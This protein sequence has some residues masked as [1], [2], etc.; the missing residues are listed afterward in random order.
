MLLAA[1]IVGSIPSLYPWG[2]AA[3]RFGERV[4]VT[5]GLGAAAI[6][7]AGAAFVS[8]FAGLVV[9]LFLAGAFGAAVNSST[10][11]AVM[12]WFG[13]SERGLALGVRQTSVPIAGFWVALTLPALVSGNDPRDAL[14]AVAAVCLAGA[15]GGLLVLRGGDRRSRRGRAAGSDARPRHLG[16]LRRQ[17]ADPRAAGVP[18]RLPG[19]VPARRA[20]PLHG[21]GRSRSRGCQR[22]RDRDPD[23]RRPLVGRRRQPAR[24]APADRARTDGARRRH[25]RRAR[26]A[27]LAPAPAPRRDRLC[28]DQLERPRVHCGGRGGRAWRGAARRSGCSRRCSPSAAGSCRSSSAR[29]WR[30]HRGGWASHSPL[31]LPLAGWATL[32]GLSG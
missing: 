32:R 3:D 2:M 5:T 26:R 29:W 8:S 31:L 21:G 14:L 28:R 13:A 17:R 11:R 18:R 10:G 9:L 7:L 16:A 12:H 20:R 6:C 24:A 25:G 19:R 23:R 22:A 1:P 4:A 15:L 27:A 30:G